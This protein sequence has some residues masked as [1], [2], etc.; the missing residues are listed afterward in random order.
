MICMQRGHSSASEQRRLT[1]SANGLAACMQHQMRMA[2]NAHAAS[3]NGG[4]SGLCSDLESDA[5]S[6]RRIQQRHWS[7]PVTSP[8]LRL[9]K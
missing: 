4:V 9:P 8:S 3:A 6:E 2:E 1:G 7:F 5:P